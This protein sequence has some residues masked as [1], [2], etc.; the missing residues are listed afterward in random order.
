MHQRIITLALF[1]AIALPVASFAETPDM[2]EIVVTATRMPQSLDKSI[3]DTTVLNAQEIRKSGASDVSTLLRSVAGVEVAQSGGLGSTS[4]VFM[5]GANSNQVLVLLDGV[6]IDSVTTGSTALEHIMLESIDRIEIVRGNVSSLYGSEAIGG[7]IQLFTKQG[8][9]APAFNT[10]WGGGNQGSQRMAAGFSGAVNDTSFSL[11]AGRVKTDGVSAMNP[12]LMAGANPNRN[13]YDNTMFDAQVKHSINADHKLSASLFSTRGNISYDNK[14][15]PAVTDV[16]NIVDNLDK[17]ALIS[18]NQF[19][20]LWHSQMR[21]AQGIDNALTY[22]NGAQISRFQT[23]NN[24]FAWQNNFNLADGQQL[25]VSAE[26]LGQAVTSSTMYTNSRRNVNSLLAG[27]LG[28][29]ASQQVQ[30]NLRHDRYSDFGAANT[31]LLGYGLSF[32]DSWRATVSI[33]NAFRAPT[34]NELFYPGYGNP[35]LMPERSVNKEA[36]LHY[37]ADGQRVDAVYFDNRISNMII[38]SATAPYLPANI[39]KATITG[40]ELSY[41]GDFGNNHIKASVTFQN[42]RDAQTGQLL[43]RR[44]REFGSIAASHDFGTW[45]VGAEV[46]YSGSRQDTNFN[47]FPYTAVTLHAYQLFNLTARYQIDKNLSLAA[48]AGNLF[49]R[50]YSEVYGYNTPGRTLFVGLSYQ[51]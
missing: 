23:V 6:R 8:R 25:S 22:L 28:E 30:L 1:G 16:N 10:S 39:N 41:S 49:N 27:Y 14:Y 43:P 34:F 33:S 44:A 13:G 46:R 3:A 24:Q 9:G 20:D 7:V 38:S 18:D 32:A 19:T 40:Q 37:A 21:L 26:H 51:Q 4:G 48:R 5:R 29:Y 42:P 12:S 11:N 31:G 17:A 35:I 2:G 45:N 50:N 36:G 15:N 47:T